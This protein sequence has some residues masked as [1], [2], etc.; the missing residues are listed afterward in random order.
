MCGIFGAVGRPQWV[1]G[2]RLSAAVDALRHRGPDS[3]GTWDSRGTTGTDLDEGTACVL[4]HTRLSIIDLSDASRQPMVSGDGRS[5]LVYNGEV[6]NFAEIRKELEAGG[7]RFVSSGD[8]EVVLKAFGRWGPACVERF[9]G[10][11]AFGVWESRKKTLFLCRD[12]LGVKPLYWTEGPCGVAFASE[13]RALLASGASERVLSPRGLLGYLRYGSMEE[14][15]TLI[16]G[17]RSLPP[18]STLTY[19]D[20]KAEV[21]R[22]WS[23]PAG[24]VGGISREEAVSGIDRLLHESVRLRLVSDVPFGIF[25][26]GGVDSSALTAIA[27]AESPRPVH[28]FTVVF[29]E[30]EYSEEQVA[31]ETAHRFGCEHHSVR[32]TGTEGA[33]TF[34]DALAA[35]DQPSQD[36]LN[37]WLV[38]R[39]ARQA[40]LSMTLSGLGS[41]EVF[42]GYENFRRFG[43]L[44]RWSRNAGR[45]PAGLLAA[46]ERRLA[47]PGARNRPRKAL[48]L[49]TARGDVRLVYGVL[50]RM[51]TDA[52][53]DM[54]VAGPAMRRGAQEREIRG[55]S[56][57]FDDLPSGVVDN[58]NLFTRLEM[59]YYLRNTLL[60]DTDAMS[61][62]SS[63]EVRVPYLDHRLL[64]FVA[65]VR[66]RMKLDRRVNKPLLVAAVPSLPA[67]IGTR[68]KVGFVLPLAEWF[69]GPM[70]KQMEEILL[71]LPG[72][73]AG[74][75]RRPSMTATWNAFVGG[76]ESV[77]ASRVF[78]L[79][80]LVMWCERHRLVLPW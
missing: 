45:L 30:T 34:G 11:F 37:T 24:P 14:P 62:A 35:Q 68:P 55:P 20:G 46:A 50:R 5:I 29:D 41:D 53:L 72:P 49:A 3:S 33:R 4:G 78:G 10:M 28:T 48:A 66:G 2:L 64:E 38:S 23:L 42:G 26:S 57:E 27:S 67:G 39:A 51:F 13:V 71:G 12:R 77:S 63:L 43:R 9:R 69:R 7:E 40:G 65:T 54:L 36:G 52:Q 44:L 25:L 70:R 76:D 59:S 80:S 22:F 21:R 47:R 8:T 74:I 75:L 32:I 31:A 73:A 19:R 17:V 60:R 6:Y 16:S 61:M 18:G 56:G 15:D 79:A 1:S 58:V